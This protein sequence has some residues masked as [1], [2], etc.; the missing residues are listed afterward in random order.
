MFYSLVR[1][2]NIKLRY[3]VFLSKEASSAVLESF[4]QHLWKIYYFQYKNIVDDEDSLVNDLAPTVDLSKKKTAT[5]MESLAALP[6]PYNRDL[7]I[8]H[9]GGALSYYHFFLPITSS[10]DL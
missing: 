3:I 9:V 1:A 10:E 4:S 2:K 5:A 6:P 8:E 7:C